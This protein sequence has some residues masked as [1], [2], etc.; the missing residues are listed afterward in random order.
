LSLDAQDWVWRYSQSKGTARLVLLAIADKAGADGTAWAGT[1]ML[2]QRTNAAR[3]SVIVAV[4]KLLAAGELETVTDRKG[5][6]G[7]T[8]YRLPHVRHHRGAR[9]A[10]G[11]ETAPVRNTDSSD[12]WSLGGA[13]PAPH[14]SDFRTPPGPEPAPQNA[15]NARRTKGTQEQAGGKRSAPTAPIDLAEFTLTDT[16]RRWAVATF[17]DSLD[18]EYETLQFI[19]HH[20]A[21]GRNRQN[22]AAEWQKWMRRSAKYYASQRRHRPLLR[23]VSGWQPWT[24]PLDHSVYQNGF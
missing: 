22:W 16:M 18:V 12:I 19:D 23:A 5:P 15:F 3:S 14:P 11:P 9:D 24:N 7:E 8:V 20:R 1:T 13:K 17:G 4:D 2:V 21:E 10:T 6:R